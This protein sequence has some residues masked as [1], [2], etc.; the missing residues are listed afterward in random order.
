LATRSSTSSLSARRAETSWTTVAVASAKYLDA[1]GETQHHPG[2]G[3][4]RLT[5]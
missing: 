5:S 4:P 3:D 2:G 1:I